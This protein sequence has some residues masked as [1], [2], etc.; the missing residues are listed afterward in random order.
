[1]FSQGFATRCLGVA[2]S[3]DAAI[4]FGPSEICTVGG[5][6]PCPPSGGLRL[7]KLQ[8]AH[9]SIG[10]SNAHH[11]DDEPMYAYEQ[12]TIT[13]HSNVHHGQTSQAKQE[14]SLSL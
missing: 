4:V 9:K 10:A 6:T 2:R 5:E 13:S 3:A 11:D 1:M 7:L 14:S 12:S 8:S